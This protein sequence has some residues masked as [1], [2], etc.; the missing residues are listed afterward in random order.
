[1]RTV[2]LRLLTARRARRARRPEAGMTLLEIMIVLAI[3]ALVMGIL[4]GPRVMEMFSD[5]KVDTAKMAV[6]KLS[7]EGYAYWSRK[8]PSKSCPESVESLGEEIDMKAD[9]EKKQLLDAW[10]NRYVMMCGQSLP[11]GAR[12]LAILS[13]GP[14][15][16]QG[17][18]DDI[19][20][21]D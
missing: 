9:K 10:G 11:P 6:R 12:G 13:L 19:R 1:M 17:T 3:L 14:D 7:S 8:N 20:S 21:W 2:L 18:D 15:G 5:S 16:K 4:I